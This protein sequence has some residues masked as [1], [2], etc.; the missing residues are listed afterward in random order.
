MLFF[1]LVACAASDAPTGTCTSSRDCGGGQVCLDERC[2]AGPDGGTSCGAGCECASDAQCQEAVPECVA[3]ACVEGSCF[4]RQE[5]DRCGGGSCDIA[6]GC[7]SGAIDSGVGD[8]GSSADAA[9]GD[10]GSLGDAGAALDA[11]APDAG[12]TPDAGALRPIGSACTDAAQCEDLAGREGVCLTTFDGESMAGGYCSVPCGLVGTCD[13]DSAC[14]RPT[15]FGRAQMCLALCRT[16]LD[17]R[18]RSYTCE[19]RESAM[20]CVP[21]GLIPIE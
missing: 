16:S 7:V 1:S 14:V 9:L 19:A 17:C 11:Q 10:G 5:D 20:V 12:P 6:R 4:F 13:A 3:A 2:A 15:T 8:A 18:G 21:G